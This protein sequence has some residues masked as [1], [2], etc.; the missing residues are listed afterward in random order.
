[1]ITSENPL[2]G[3]VANV[4]SAARAIGDLGA[5]VPDRCAEPNCVLHLFR[6]EIHQSARRHGVL[7]E[8][9][10]HAYEYAV[11]WVELGDDPP[12]YL[13]V[14]PA[15][16]GNLLELVV[17]EADGGELMIHAMA[18]RRSTEHELFGGGG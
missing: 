10:E 8:D 1:M 12:R 13:V 4:P 3:R 7:D 2:G 6:V 16:A 17:M 9:I 5:V 11:E 14:G 18:L 15:R